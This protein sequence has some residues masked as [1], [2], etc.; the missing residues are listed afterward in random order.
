MKFDKYL[1]QQK[2]NVNR[3][4][5]NLIEIFIQRKAQNNSQSLLKYLFKE[6]HTIIIFLPSSL[7]ISQMPIERKIETRF[8]GVIID[9]SLK[10]SRHVKT[11]LS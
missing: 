8:L 5:C 3:V 6:K 7:I 1:M 4:Q 11:I 9:D 2:S 10:W